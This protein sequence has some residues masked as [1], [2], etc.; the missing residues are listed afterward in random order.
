[1]PERLI[2]IMGI[3]GTGKST[4]GKA[5]AEQMNYTFVDADDFHSEQAKTMMANGEAI[6]DDMR[7]Q[8]ITSMLLQL[9]NEQRQRESIVLA[10][11][12][13]KQHQRARFTL[14]S[15]KL[16]S[17]LLFGDKTLI[18]KRLAQ[19]SAHFFSPQL[20]DNQ[21]EALEL[22]GT[23]N[24]EAITLINIEQPVNDIVHHICQTLTA[25]DIQS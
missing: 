15:T 20:L 4:I 3:S 21:L 14:L 6:T 1:M 2:L 9:S 5:V 24:S 8:W 11:S 25:W 19:R 12:G 22:P 18:A 7:D 10:Y 16:K 17:F 13:L 23:S